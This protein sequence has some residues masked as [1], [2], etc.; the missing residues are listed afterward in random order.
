MQVSIFTHITTFLN[1][2]DPWNFVWNQDIEEV[3][4]KNAIQKAAFNLLSL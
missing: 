4:F 2:I 1:F 3:P